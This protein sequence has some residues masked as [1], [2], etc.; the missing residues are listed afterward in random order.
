MST[1]THNP[2]RPPDPHWILHC[3]IAQLYRDSTR[4]S[5]RDR[6][7]QMIAESER[8]A[9]EAALALERQRAQAP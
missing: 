4:V 7:P 2:D 5:E 9:I 8:K 3:K 6:I 1:P